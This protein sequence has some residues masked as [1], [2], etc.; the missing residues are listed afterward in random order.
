MEIYFIILLC[1]IIVA[2][3]II[4]LYKYFLSRGASGY[5]FKNTKS[6]FEPETFEQTNPHLMAVSRNEN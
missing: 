1:I 3:I 2:G 4:E 6:T 5:L